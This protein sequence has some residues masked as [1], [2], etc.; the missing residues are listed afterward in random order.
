M[1]AMIQVLTAVALALTSFAAVLLRFCRSRS[2]GGRR[3]GDAADRED[4]AEG[5]RFILAEGVRE[6]P[7]EKYFAGE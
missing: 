7:Q 6:K 3:E 5:T 2:G 4:L 1:R